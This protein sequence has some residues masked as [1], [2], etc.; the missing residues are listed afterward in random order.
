MSMNKQSIVFLI[1]GLIIGASV[2]WALS[3]KNTKTAM[4]ACE[5]H[6]EMAMDK[7][8]ESMSMESM[9]MDMNASLAGKTGEEFDKAFID[10]MI[11]HHQGAID[12]ANLALTNAEHEEIK[13]LS[14]DIITAQTK[15]IE[16]MK[17]WQKMWGYNTNSNN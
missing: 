1:F 15:E 8:H 2:T 16:Q 3:T 7:N 5:M 14:N 11:I 4:N 13:N 6:G 12:M 17:S 10:E 9:M